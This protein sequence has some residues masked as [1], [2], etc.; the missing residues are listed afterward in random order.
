MYGLIVIGD[1]LSS[2]VAAAVAS[3]Q[4]IKTALIAENGIG[5]VC[6]IGDLVFDT[7]T[8]PFT[9]L[10][11]NQICF[12]LLK[13]MG[14]D[15]EIN[16]LNPAYQIILP[17]NRIDFFN[18]KEELVTEMAREFPDLAKEIKSYYYAIEK[19]RLQPKN[20]SGSIP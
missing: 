19:T 16:L 13:E 7:D 4:G 3:S 12:S 2:H 20:G 17:E 15:P 8:T 1:D 14:I 6:V 11:E 18:N 9:G 10:G 5:S